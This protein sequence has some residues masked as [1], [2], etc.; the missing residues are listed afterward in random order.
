MTTSESTSTFRKA[1]LSHKMYNINV[2][3]HISALL[4]N[5]YYLSEFLSQ[6]RLT[7]HQ[8]IN[9]VF[10]TITCINLPVKAKV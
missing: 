9:T 4:P 8:V 10:F 1:Y 5:Y 6:S 2:V 7:E 3:L